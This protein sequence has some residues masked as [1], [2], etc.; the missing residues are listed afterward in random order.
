MK[1]GSL[2]AKAW[3]VV[4]HE[5]PLKLLRRVIL[6]ITKRHW[7]DF[8]PGISEEQAY[9]LLLKKEQL[10]IKEILAAASS[11]IK[12]MTYKPVISL[13]VP[14]VDIDTDYLE[15]T[16][17]SILKQ[18]YPFWEIYTATDNTT[19]K[20]VDLYKRYQNI[21]AKFK[22]G[23]MSSNGSVERF[24]NYSIS[25]CSGDFIG[26]LDCGDELAP[27]ALL[28]MAKLLNDDPAVDVI[29]SDEDHLSNSN[30]RTAPLFK[31]GWSPDLLLSMNYVGRCLT[32]RKSMLDALG[33]LRKIRGMHTVMTCFCAYQN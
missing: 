31:P 25:I 2:F 9:F 4:I 22:L 6:Y 17:K 10:R 18:S 30:K 16:L 7:S 26:F 3:W 21:N 20:L 32:V 33:G 23:M 1:S 27:H 13:I 5:G 11:D 14:L 8:S 24:V 19:L 28:E 15:Q 12:A 29:Y